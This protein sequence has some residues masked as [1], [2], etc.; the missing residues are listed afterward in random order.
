MDLE[1]KQVQQIEVPSTEEEIDKPEHSHRAHHASR[2]AEEP[3]RGLHQS[4]GEQV[5]AGQGGDHGVP[6]PRDTHT[7]THTQT[8]TNTHTPRYRP[9]APPL[10]PEHTQL[11]PRCPE[12]PQLCA[13][14]AVPPAANPRSATPTPSGCCAAA[15]H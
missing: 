13:L 4:H 8:N 3:G 11:L 14:S 1:Q 6:L 5:Q 7:N 9:A 12:G 15:S 2:P 10:G